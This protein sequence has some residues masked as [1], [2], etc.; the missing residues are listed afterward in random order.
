[1]SL[2]HYSVNKKCA[3]QIFTCR[4]IFQHLFCFLF[5]LTT[6]RN[7]WNSVRFCQVLPE[8]EAVKPAQP[9]LVLMC[10]KSKPRFLFCLLPG[11]ESVFELKRARKGTSPPIWCHPIFI[12][13]FYF[14]IR[15][16]WDFPPTHPEYRLSCFSEKWLYFVTCLPAAFRRCKP[17][18]RHLSCRFCFLP[19]CC[20]LSHVQILHHLLEICLYHTFPHSSA[21]IFTFSP[22]FTKSPSGPASRCQ[23]WTESLLIKRGIVLRRQLTCVVCILEFSSF[24]LVKRQ[25]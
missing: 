23:T 19:S 22:A 9:T 5:V 11:P 3:A 24:I 14:G 25:N 2:P 7:S 6:C 10:V 4:Q 1:M 18:A 17:T 21:L 8:S 13:L 15:C 16:S 12:Y 20:Q